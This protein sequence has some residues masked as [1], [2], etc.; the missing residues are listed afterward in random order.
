M[1]EV[2]LPCAGH[3]EQGGGSK[4]RGG[5]LS[6]P[7][8]PRLSAS[9]SPF[10]LSIS[11]CLHL[12]LTRS[13]CII[14]PELSVSPLG[15]CL[16]SLSLCMTPLPLSPGKGPSESCPDLAKP[17]G[18]VLRLPGPPSLGR[19]G[20]RAGSP[21][22]PLTPPLLSP[23]C[24]SLCVS[25]C[26]GPARSGPVAATCCARCCSPWRCCWPWLSPAPYS[27]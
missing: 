24:L 22:L 25:V 20:S 14:G 9:V 6:L 2:C 26:A 17:R 7:R 8:S 19:A 12:S 3:K 13:C 1:E 27:S 4:G 16:S 21:A 10:I 18:P 5:R 11:G 23:V 15:F